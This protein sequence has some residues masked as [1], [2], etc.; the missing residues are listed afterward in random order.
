M[1]LNSASFIEINGEIN[2]SKLEQEYVLVTG[3]LSYIGSHTV[4]ELLKKDVKVIIIDNL[5]T[6][7]ITCLEKLRIISNKPKS[8]IFY[9]YDLSNENAISEIFTTFQI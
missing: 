8:I 5:E 2:D 1:R 3:G 6:S 9:Q 7:S 4:L